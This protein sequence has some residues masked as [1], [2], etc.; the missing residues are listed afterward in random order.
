VK[1]VTVRYFAVL[2]EQRGLEEE[3]VETT[4]ATA[5]EVYE[6]L[7]RTHRLALPAGSLRV[8]VNHEFKEWGEVIRDGDT[9]A[10]IPP[11]AGG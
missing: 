10:F 8:A 4:A 2:R 9:L 11:F 5:A 3:R 7:R 6:E 1:R